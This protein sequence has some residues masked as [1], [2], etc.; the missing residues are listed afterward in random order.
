MQG[1]PNA[2]VT[3]PYA[4]APAP[5]PAPIASL[6]TAATRF[7]IT[8]LSKLAR[9]YA[10]HASASG[11]FKAPVSAAPNPSAIAAAPVAGNTRSGESPATASG[12]PPTGVTSTGVP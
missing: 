3:Q 2:V 6:Y 12:K 10:R 5:P 4:Q 11:S 7:A 9:A 1:N 8:E